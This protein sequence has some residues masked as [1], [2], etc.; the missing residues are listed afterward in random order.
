MCWGWNE[1]EC[2]LREV[3][4]GLDN[5]GRMADWK[6]MMLWKMKVWRKGMLDKTDG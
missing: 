5:G 1:F 3:N 6:G 4:V 2:V